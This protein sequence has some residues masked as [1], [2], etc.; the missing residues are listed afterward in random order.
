MYIFLLTYLIRL[1]TLFCFPSD[2]DE[3]AQYYDCIEEYGE[4]FD[5]CYNVCGENEVCTNTIGSNNCTCVEGYNRNYYTYDC[6]RESLEN[7]LY[8]G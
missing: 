6:I 5:Y 7:I 4:D 1:Y 8:S 3:C 2:I